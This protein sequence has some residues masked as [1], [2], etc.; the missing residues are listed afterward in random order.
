MTHD[1]LYTKTQRD[2]AI[3][4]AQALT[5]INDRLGT[6]EVGQ[7]RILN[8]LEKC[9]TSC[10]GNRKELNWELIKLKDRVNIVFTIGGVGVFLLGL[11][12][13]LKII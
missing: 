2:E 4:L 1:T 9:N 13:K 3:E 11:A 7:V 10:S 5:S 8:S 6:I 12:I